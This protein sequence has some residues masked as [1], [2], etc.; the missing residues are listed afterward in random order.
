MKKITFSILCL[1][2]SYSLYSQTAGI[3]FNTGFGKPI[4]MFDAPNSTVNYQSAM[5][6]D[7]R[8][9]IWVG[10]FDKFSGGLL[11][12]T[13]NV[14]ANYVNPDGLASEF[15]Y[16]SLLIDIPMRYSFENSFVKSLSVG[17][18][19]NILMNSNQTINGNPVY[20]DQMFKSISWSAGVELTFRGYEGDA[21]YL[22]PYMNY[23]QMLTSV[24]MNNA[25]ET[26]NLNSFSLGLRCDIP[27]P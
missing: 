13:F 21:F 6:N 9:G 11:F 14:N 12:G 18:C 25:N 10:D 4:V 2:F 24:D 22:S 23:K 19:M 17:P 20:N 16:S 3:Q 7:T 1:L 8:L 5:Y 15:Q 26:L 27:L